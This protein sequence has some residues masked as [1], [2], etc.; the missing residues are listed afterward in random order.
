MTKNL[1]RHPPVIFWAVALIAALVLAISACQAGK[2]A[3]RISEVTTAHAEPSHAAALRARFEQLPALVAADDHGPLA[4]FATQAGDDA[5]DAAKRRF[6][7]FGALDHIAGAY[8]AVAV[9]AFELADV[10][11]GADD[12]NVPASRGASVLAAS[13]LGTAGDRLLHI[14]VGADRDGLGEL[15]DYGLPSNDITTGYPYLE[16]PAAPNGHRLPSHADLRSQLG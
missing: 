12:D 3:D 16:A 6:E 2:D 7:A 13:R 5:V 10:A 14:A 8:R 1:F 15:S 9:A 4:A 11:D